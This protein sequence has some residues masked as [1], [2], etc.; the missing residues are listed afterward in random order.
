MIY[1]LLQVI[2]AYVAASQAE[3]PVDAVSVEQIFVDVQKQL[4]ALTVLFPSRTIADWF[5]EERS[6]E[7]L[8]AHLQILLSGG[9][10]AALSQ[11]GQ[12]EAAS[13]GEEGQ[14]IRGSY[15]SPQSAGGGRRKKR[16]KAGGGP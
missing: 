9:V 12:Q 4:T 5:A 1:N 11:G 14:G 13:E 16:L 3:M 2:R 15:L 6:R 7:E 8:I 10:D